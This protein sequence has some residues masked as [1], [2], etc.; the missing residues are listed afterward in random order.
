MEE[1]ERSRPLGS[2]QFWESR[3]GQNGSMRQSHITE[4]FPI[5]NAFLPIT[6]SVVLVFI[7]VHVVLAIKLSFL[8]GF[9]LVSFR[10]VDHGFFLCHLQ[11]KLPLPKVAGVMWPIAIIHFRL[12]EALFH[13]FLQSSTETIFVRVNNAL[14]IE[15]VTCLRHWEKK[16]KHF[17]AFDGEI[18][19]WKIDFCL[20]PGLIA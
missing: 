9:G 3:S 11:N 12:R 8:G 7:A 19:G 17:G 6:A 5:W 4:N 1:T 14:N 13:L 18:N 16:I 2:Y 10:V 20:K 15:K